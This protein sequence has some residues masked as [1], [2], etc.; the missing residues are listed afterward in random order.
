ML[1]KKAPSLVI[2]RCEQL[3]PFA[4]VRSLILVVE[5]RLCL[6]QDQFA[7]VDLSWRIFLSVPQA[8]V[9]NWENFSDLDICSPPFVY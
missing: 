3:F 9:V 4:N 5:Y 1:N 6:S 7:M 8:K 2:K